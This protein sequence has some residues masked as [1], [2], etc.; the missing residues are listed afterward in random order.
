MLESYLIAYL[1]RIENATGDEMKAAFE[2]FGNESLPSIVTRIA[3][4]NEAVMTIA[5]PLSPAGPSPLARFF[6]FS[7]TGYFDIIAAAKQLKNDP[8]VTDVRVA[9]DTPGG[10][11]SGMDAA[12]QALA[13][14]VAAKN[15]TAENHGVIASAGYYLASA[16]KKI[17]AMS[18]LAL[19][20]SLGILIAGL[21]T[22]EALA[23]NGV[24]RVRIVSQ[25]APNKSPDLNTTQ[26]LGV[27]RDEINAM[28]RVFIR[29]I[30]QGRGVTD[31]K[32]IADFGK[33][34]V[35]IAQDPDP[36]KPDAFKMGM[37]DAVISSGGIVADIDPEGDGTAAMQIDES[38]ANIQ[39]HVEKLEIPT[40][41]G[42]QIMDLQKLKSEH[43]ALYA[44]VIGIGVKQERDRV[45][46]HLA[47]GT[48]AED[49]PLAMT[50]IKD[51]SE[52][53]PAINAKYMASNMNKAD[54]LARD[55]ESAGD[56]PTATEA[57]IAAAYQTALATATA[58]ALGV[59][60]K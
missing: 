4:S 13:E 57:E 16:V 49:M 58:K 52:F 5:G 26:G 18:P 24:K 27:I 31:E 12:R 39:T 25:N 43:P 54:R 35:M 53:T 46:A 36:E 1:E 37:I 7:G 45:D 40:T 3:G 48:A 56:I 34:G 44:E 23:R 51:G 55:K 20:G 14:L 2:R 30:A 29:V 42:T 17:T 15:V 8:T 22:S 10:T 19:T 33:G 47:M 28:E 60:I 9:F 50:C 21:D 32:V 59:D 38:S 41:R 6:G 11:V